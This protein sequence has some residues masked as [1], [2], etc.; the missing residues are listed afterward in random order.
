MRLFCGR[1]VRVKELSS[2]HHKE[3]GLWRCKRSGAN[4]GQIMGLGPE[5]SHYLGILLISLTVS[6]ELNVLSP[7]TAVPRYF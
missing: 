7:V 6:K 4:S 5:D 2:G 3:R 1:D